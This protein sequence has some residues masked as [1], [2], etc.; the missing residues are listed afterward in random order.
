V[1]VWFACRCQTKACVIADQLEICGHEPRSRANAVG[2]C[3]DSASEDGRYAWTKVHVGLPM[4][5]P[6]TVDNSSSL[7][8]FTAVFRAC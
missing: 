4:A 2:F 1:L 8:S 3:S 6:G 5:L 7:I